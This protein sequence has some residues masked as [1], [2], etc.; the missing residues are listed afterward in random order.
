[1]SEP[2]LRFT[3]PVAHFLDTGRHSDSRLHPRRL[4]WRLDWGSLQYR[5]L[6]LGETLSSVRWRSLFTH[7]NAQTSRGKNLSRVSSE[8]M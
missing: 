7:G 8:R 3:D 6:A 4:S 1:M 2:G 5:V